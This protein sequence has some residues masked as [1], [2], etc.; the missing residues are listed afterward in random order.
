MPSAPV[1]DE[2]RAKRDGCGCYSSEQTLSYVR[3]V[4][5]DGQVVSLWA[6]GSQPWLIFDVCGP[7]D[8]QHGGGNCRDVAWGQ[9]IAEATAIF[10]ARAEA[11]CLGED[12]P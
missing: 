5:I 2:L 10:D 6:Y 12:G 11:L 1:R 3:C 7:T 4:H 8:G 9:P